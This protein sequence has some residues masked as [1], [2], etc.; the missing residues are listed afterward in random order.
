MDINEWSAGRHLAVAP[1]AQ[2]IDESRMGRMP[3]ELGPRL[4]CVGA[5]IEQQDFGEVFAQACPGLVVG[6]GDRSWSAGCDGGRLGYLGDGRV[7]SVT[8]YE[9]PAS[10]VG[11]Q[12]AAVVIREVRDVD[13]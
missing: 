6:T 2:L 5:L 3:V 12:H 1:V 8:D 9:V 7:Q 10:R 11:F 13:C 4:G